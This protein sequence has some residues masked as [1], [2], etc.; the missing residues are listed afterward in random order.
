[1]QG[2]LR[3]IAPAGLTLIETMRWEPGVGAIRRAGHF[4]RLD[5]GC[6]AL[7]ISR[8]PGA[9]EA[10]IDAVT[11]DAP[12]RL[13]LTVDLAGQAELTTAPLPPSKEVW[14]VQIAEEV[15]DST[16]P[17]RALKTTERGL[18]DRA[19]AQLA[20]GVDE[21]IFVNERGE[22]VEGTITNLF[23]ERDGALLTPPLASGALPGVLRAELLAQGRAREAVLRPKDLG[24]G[25]LFLGNSLRGLITA[26]VI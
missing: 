5:A 9:A 19:R 13:R 22:L 11:G 6:A 18:Y 24:T 4:A 1:M 23:L 2:G 10:L 25:R 20:P 8:E 21:A 15:L 7:G 3:A 26:E 14:R 17:W 12:L 16:V